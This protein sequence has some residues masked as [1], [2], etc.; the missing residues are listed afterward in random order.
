MLNGFKD[1]IKNAAF[2]SRELCSFVWNITAPVKI[3]ID[4][5]D[6]LLPTPDGLFEVFIKQSNARNHQH[7]A[8]TENFLL[9]IDRISEQGAK[10]N[11]DVCRSILAIGVTG[12]KHLQN[13]YEEKR[14]V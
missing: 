8:N 10:A 9:Q 12:D 11:R 2:L 1:L 14:L 6:K 5:V 4:R 3:N 7:T 13:K